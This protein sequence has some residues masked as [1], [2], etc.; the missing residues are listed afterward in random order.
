VTV[1]RQEPLSAGGDRLQGAAGQPA[2][3]PP[4][5]PAR[6][7]A[8]APPSPAE[9]Q[10]ARLKIGVDANRPLHPKTGRI[11]AQVADPQ[12]IASTGAGWVRLNFVL[13][14]WSGPDDET[15]F[16]GRTWAQ[17]YDQIIAGFRR[18]GLQVYG[19]VGAEAMPTGPG[20]RFRSPPPNGRTRAEWLDRYVDQFVAIV[21]R[22][23]QDVAVFES[24]NEPDDWHG[25]D[26][27][28]IHPAWFA[29]M[30]QRLYTA[31]R[32]HPELEQV[33]LVSGPV[34]GLESNRNAA[35]TYLLRTYRAGKAWFGWGRPGMPFPFDGIGYHLYVEGGF[36]TDQA[37]QERTV[38][39]TCRR[40]LAGLQ[41]LI[42]QEEGRDRPLYVSEVGWSSRLEVRVNRRRE[43]LLEIRRR[44]AFQAGCLR[45]GLQTLVADPQVAVAFWFCTQ[46]FGTATRPIYYGLYRPGKP[47]PRTR[48]P[49]FYAF[50]EVCDGIAG[51]G[52]TAGTRPALALGLTSGPASPGC[53]STYG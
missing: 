42:R 11:E 51:Q 10:P 23:H 12:I 27:N 14:P 1:R 9:P 17:A 4:Q 24:L 47:G 26:R 34:Q 2:A 21:R 8:S 39:T 43:E 49:A 28:W 50:R 53:P 48:K 22:F 37:R 20:D 18:Q 41:Q 13:G 7:P 30:L 32:Q 15:L 40:Y 44:E 19:L 31:V 29:V 45:A 46:D 25:Q 52:S 16:D 33:H 35:V 38:R 36:V 3:V 6:R 5:D